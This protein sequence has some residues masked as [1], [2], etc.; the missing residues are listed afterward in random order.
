MRLVREA[1]YPA[2]EVF[3]VH[4]DGMVLERVD[5]STML[6]DLATHPWRVQRHATRWARVGIGLGVPNQS[7]LDVLDAIWRGEA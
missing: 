3:E 6:D 7:D 1:G 4:G 5:G 2:P